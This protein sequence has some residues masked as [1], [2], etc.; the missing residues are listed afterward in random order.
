MGLDFSRVTKPIG[1]IARIREVLRHRY[2]M[3]L[4]ESPTACLADVIN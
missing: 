1:D 2:H 3:L 4:L